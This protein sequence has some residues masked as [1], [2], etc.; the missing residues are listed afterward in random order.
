MPNEMHRDAAGGSGPGQRRIVFALV[1]LLL[2]LVALWAGSAGTRRPGGS[3]PEL[4]DGSKEGGALP[5]E[6]T[7]FAMGTYVRLVIAGQQAAETVQACLDELERLE[8]VFD[9]FQPDS[10]LSRLNARAG[11]GWVA[12]S[13]ELFVALQV[14]LEVA[15][16]SDGAYDPTVAPLVD[17]W[18]FREEDGRIPDHAPPPSAGIASAIAKVDYRQVQVDNERR[19]VLLPAGMELDL[20]G[21][22]KGYALDRLAGVAGELGVESALMDLGGN[23]RV[24][25]D[26]PAGGP[27]RIAVRHPRGSGRIY[28]VLP[29]SG[30]AVATSGDYQRYFT[31]KGRRYS[32]IL[33]PRTGHPAA[34]L[35]SVTVIAPSGALSDALSTAAF[36]LGP[37][38]GKAFLESI[39]GVE[40][41]FVD[42]KLRM[43]V[44]RG[45]EGIVE[46]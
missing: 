34:S 24:L 16:K 30:K 13:D 28:A 9:R 40:G 42:A 5:V 37:K 32:H 2:G 39:P 3:A 17:T 33:D 26:R 27:W 44:T 6:R 7:A 36:V 31:W 22:A 29:V 15:E 10:E 21:V 4:E 11:A 12:V 45:L 25:G 23:I 38:A 1:V 8:E 41:L 19:R 43:T 35:T 18:G 14:A 46:R 20:G